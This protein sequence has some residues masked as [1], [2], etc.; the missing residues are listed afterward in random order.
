[1][2][3][4]YTKKT[5][6]LMCL[7]SVTMSVRAEIDWISVTL[8]NDLFVG[9]DNGYTNGLYVSVFDVGEKSG[10]PPSHDFWVLPLMWIMPKQGVEFAANAYALGQTMSTPS[11]ITIAVPD[12]DELP[13]SALLAMTNSYVTVSQGHA[14]RVSTTIGIVGPAALGEEVQKFVHKIIGADE[15]L[16]WDTQLENELVF[17]LSRAR[18]WRTWSSATDHLDVLTL[19]EASAGT[20]QSGV[21]SGMMI[22]YGRNLQESYVTTLFSNSRTINPM[23]VDGG[24]YTYFG[25]QLDYIF[26]QIFTDG[27]TFRDSRSID[28]DHA[29]IGVTTGIAYSWGNYALTFAFSD[30]DVLQD[31]SSDENVENLTRF[32]T[33]SFAWRY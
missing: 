13:Y 6:L 21:G 12:E 28:Y 17:Q 10:K 27:N 4:T 11:D 22:R 5:L 29:T 31:E 33:L 24:W 7:C 26:N 1:M 2:L 14:D 9:N 20:L 3:N 18:I 32:G 19:A 25:L 16:G 23:A 30:F 8:D 15:P